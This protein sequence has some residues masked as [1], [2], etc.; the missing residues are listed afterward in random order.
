MPCRVRDEQADGHGQISG[1]TNV[2]EVALRPK[3]RGVFAASPAG[4]GHGNH[5]GSS[6]PSPARANHSGGSLGDRSD[7]SFLK[8]WATGTNP[9]GGVGH[10]EVWPHKA[11]PTGAIQN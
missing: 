10:Y 9:M 8:M 5:D 6:G 1:G 11:S 7:Q 3:P 2:R 4:R